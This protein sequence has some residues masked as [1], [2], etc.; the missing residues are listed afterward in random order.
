[1]RTRQ[2]IVTSITIV[3]MNCVLFSV[4]GYGQGNVNHNFWSNRGDGEY[5]VEKL[6]CHVDG[7]KYEISVMASDLVDTVSWLPSTPLPLSV[8]NV[9]SLAKKKLEKLA[10]K[11]DL[12]IMKS[13]EIKYYKPVDKWYFVVNFFQP[14]D[15]NGMGYQYFCVPINFNGQVLNI[16]HAIEIPNA[17][18]KG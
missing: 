12:W 3:L 9:I 15:N 7:R 1:M 5:T 17:T 4:G 18:P 10:T 14:I 2:S 16:K 6:W 8:D 11:P 13:I